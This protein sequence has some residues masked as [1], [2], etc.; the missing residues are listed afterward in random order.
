MIRRLVGQRSRW[1]S[2]LPLWA[3]LG[4]GVACSG[5]TTQ[6]VVESPSGSS[7]EYGAPQNTSF[8]AEVFPEPDVVHITLYERSDC[9][10][11]E[12]ETVSRRRETLEGSR[13]VATTE[14]GKAQ[15]V[16]GVQGS[17]P[18]QQRYS[19]GAEVFL[20]VGKG[21][22]PIGTTNARGAIST[23][24]SERLKADVYGAPERDVVVLVRA[25]GARGAGGQPEHGA[26]GVAW[27]RGAHAS[28]DHPL[29]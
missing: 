22:Y 11:I 3:L 9:E 18:C 2:A 19:S 7:V 14:L 16:K 6:R 17:V 13:V 1:F 24:L 12:V 25:A 29:L 26:L 28:G 8:V 15:R 4:G 27:Q 23:E 20:K 21:V 5:A 10:R